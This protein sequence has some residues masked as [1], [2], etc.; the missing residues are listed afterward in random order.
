MWWRAELGVCATLRATCARLPTRRSPC[1]RVAWDPPHTLSFLISPP[2]LPAGRAGRVIR[3][4]SHLT[5]RVAP[6]EQRVLTQATSKSRLQRRP[7][8]GP[9]RRAKNQRPELRYRIDA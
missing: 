5:L 7:A 3:R 8:M 6:G 1:E 9:P 4:K 2:P